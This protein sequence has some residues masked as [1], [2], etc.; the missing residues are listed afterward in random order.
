MS[1][2]RSVRAGLRKLLRRADADREL[3]DELRHYL[4]L[5]INEKMRAGLS[6]DAAERA[7]RI[8]MG[9]VQQAKETVRSAGWE[10]HVEILAQD[11]RYAARSLRRSPAVSAAVILT[12]ALGVGANTTMFSVVNAVVLRPL[13]YRDA[14]RVALLW[15]DD[16][17]RGLHREPTAYRTITEWRARSR[18]FQN[19][20]YFSRGRVTPVREGDP[21]GRGRSLG[22]LVSG[23]LFSV[24]GAHPLI[25]RTI[26][27]ADETDRAPVAVI[28]YDF[29]QRWFSGTPDV[30]GRSLTI[31]D[32][33]KGGTNT[34]TVIGVMSPG[35]FFPDKQVEM[36]TPATSY[37]R[38]AR[39]AVE[40]FPDWA[41]RWTAVARLSPSVSIN[42]AQREMSRIGRDLAAAFPSTRSDFPGF[43]VTVA[44]VLDSI[45][46]VRLQSGLW[47]LLGATGLV[48]LI[49]CANIANLLLARGALRQHEFAVRRA[50]G[51]GRARLVRLLTVE[52]LML[53][54]IGG[55]IGIGIAAFA[56]PLL[57]RLAASS[58]PRIEEVSIDFHVLGFAAVATMLAA[59]IFG[60]APAFRLARVDPFDALREGG[61]GTG[62]RRV[63]SLRSLVVLAECALAVL[64]LAGAGLLLRSLGRVNAVDPGFDP[65]RVL[66][67][68][69]EWGPEA[70]T[71]GERANPN[72]AGALSARAHEQ[73]AQQL[74]AELRAL[75]GAADVG[76][77][78]DFFIGGSANKSIT[79][80]G[81]GDQSG[82]EVNN[83]DV[84]PD[85]FRAMGVPV[86]RGRALTRDDAMQKIRALFTPTP[87]N[88]SLADKERLTV[89]E[90]VVVNE[91]F[92]RRFFA[93]DDPLGQRFCIDPTG[94]TY[95][96]VIVGVVGD[97][98]RQGLE[99]AAVPEYFGS[100]IPRPYGRADLVVRT[101]GDPL[102]LA[103]LVRRTITRI[104]GT[105]VASVGTA[106]AQFGGFGATRRLETSLLVTFAALALT[107]AAIGIFGLVHYAVAERTREIGIRIA[108]GATPGDVL[109]AVVARGMRMPL[110]G[111]TLGLLAAAGL[112]RTMAHLLFNVGATD[113]TT[114]ATVAVLLA[115]VAVVACY[116]AGRRG[117]R[118]D[119]VQAL[120]ES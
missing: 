5:T 3:D 98:H 9:G 110:I 99:R 26:S 76:F 46:G 35:F 50:L 7:A 103:P 73:S 63:T 4:E 56:T 59:L 109:G 57:G 10:S 77:I 80:P 1:M 95:W 20:A 52:N 55:A 42:D 23:N 72:D 38:F 116:M 89:A 12:L 79:I 22:A 87:T 33:A 114:F 36:W 6:R 49:S 43:G 74:S 78:D 37:W 83:G 64:L 120:R 93:G 91:T 16:V 104:P 34:L 70:P 88:A 102:A 85:F 54:L 86:L 81:R 58:V 75:P 92:A 71:A 107:L 13:P 45:T 60:A 32:P 105:V 67:V 19:I 24:L 65:R 111:I 44:T 48:L 53:A 31:D 21:N 112:T 84:S 96:Y 18:A 117:T 11:V 40:F 100:Y 25:G 39:E 69:V 90:P 15:T 118:V 108:L 8:E 30:I 61:R 51:G 2:W 29:W 68:R 17:K 27:P 94:K 115:T 82:F 66:T 119:P 97:M 41:R 106:E 47:L 101:A 14:G 62:S 28:S 113:P